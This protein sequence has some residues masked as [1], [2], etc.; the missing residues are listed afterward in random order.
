LRFVAI[1]PSLC[2]TSFVTL[3]PA[4]ASEVYTMRDETRAFLAAFA[5]T[6]RASDRRR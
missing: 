3:E 2:Q 1:E 5:I 6:L 4:F